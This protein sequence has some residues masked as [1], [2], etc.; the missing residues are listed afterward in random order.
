MKKF[1]FI[2]TFGIILISLPTITSAEE[3]RISGKDR[4]EVAVN[5]SKQNWPQG[6]NTVFISN[7][8]AFAD[9][10]SATPLAYQNDA[11]ILL[12]HPGS[13]T[14]LTKQELIRLKPQQVVLVGGT[15][16]LNNQIVEDL[17]ALNIP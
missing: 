14:E 1:I 11:P 9:A 4:F 3:N 16:S 7:Y 2:L 8:L 5:I 15:G 10:L 12:S 17:K 6:A 13:L